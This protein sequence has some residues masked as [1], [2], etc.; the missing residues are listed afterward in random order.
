MAWAI[1]GGAGHVG[2]ALCARLRSDGHAVRLLDVCAPPHPPEGAECLVGSVCS[3]AD[4]RRL[5]CAPRAAAV[6]AVVHLAGA[7]M[8]GADMLDAQLCHRVNV[9]GTRNVVACATRLAEESPTPVLLIYLSTYNVCFH[10]QEVYGGDETA[11][12]SPAAAHTDCYGAS[13][14]EAERLVLAAD[15]AADGALRTVALR[16]GAIFG[17]AETRHLPRIIRLMK[18]GLFRFAIGS[19]EARQD[20]LHVSNLVDAVL[21]VADALTTAPSAPPRGLPYFINDDEPVNTLAFF[22]P[23]AKALG[24]RD[25]PFVRV[26]LW[27]A[28]VMAWVCEMMWYW[29]RVPPFMT[30]AEVFKSAVQHTYSCRRAKE[31]WGYKPTVNSTTAMERLAMTFRVQHERGAPLG[32]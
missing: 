29:L 2:Q 30:R 32:R 18:L 24:C 31:D 3:A 20:W 17:E 19:A 15:G 26:P 7:G 9:E 4:V 28:I 16:P 6:A 27:V 23:L 13:K 21:R 10:G 25:Q 14:A 8:S 1:T 5:L 12:Y 11:P 22:S